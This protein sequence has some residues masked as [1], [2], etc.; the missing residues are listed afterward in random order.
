MASGL[1]SKC[2]NVHDNQ[3]VSERVQDIIRAVVRRTLGHEPWNVR[4]V[5]QW[6]RH[7]ISECSEGL[8]TLPASHSFRF[9]VTCV[10][11]KRKTCNLSAPSIPPIT[12]LT[13]QHWDGDRDGT[14]CV[15]EGN[16]SISC[17]TT[18]HAWRQKKEFEELAVAGF[19][20]LLDDVSDV[21]RKGSKQR[22]GTK[23]W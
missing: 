17:L 4:Y 2:S 22:H 13:S 16:D 15:E 19:V 1:G 3:F 14:V 11:I 20:S 5:S 12:A 21:A 7:I 18:V 23:G 10:I 6:C 8:D 9:V